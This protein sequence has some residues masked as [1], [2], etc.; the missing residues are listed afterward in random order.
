MIARSSLVNH[1]YIPK[2]KR[3][4]T[5]RVIVTNV[6]VPRKMWESTKPDVFMT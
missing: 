6:P 3:W 5:I 4:I 2:I 1:F